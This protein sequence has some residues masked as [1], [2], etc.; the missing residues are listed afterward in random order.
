MA[1]KEKD[2]RVI[3]LANLVADTRERKL[4]LTLLK[5]KDILD[6]AE[7]G[8]VDFVRLR[9][10]VWEYN[11]LQVLILVLRQDFSIIPGEWR[12]AVRLVDLLSQASSG[13]NLPRQEMRQFQEHHLPRALDYIFLLTRRIQAQ[14]TALKQDE[15]DQPERKKMEYTGYIKA[16]MESVVY[17]ASGYVTLVAEIL[18]SPWLLQLLITDEP[19]TVVAV[20]TM[21]DKVIR[22]YG[23]ALSQ[24]DQKIVYSIL[25]EL[26]YK[27]SVNNNVAVGAAATKCI[28]KICDAFRLIVDV[29]CTRYKGL[30]PLLGKWH[31]KGFARE[32]KQ[33]LVLLDTGSA[34][35]AEM[36]KYHLAAIYLQACWKGC[37][38]RIKLRRANAAFKKFQ[39]T[40]RLKKEKEERFR[41]QTKIDAEFYHH[42]KLNR[43]RIMREFKERRLHLI[44]IMP[45]VQIPRF[46]Q[47]EQSDAAVKIQ[48][49]WRGHKERNRLPGRQEVAR[50]VKAVIK[51]Q[52]TVRRWMDR[53]DKRR[54]DVTI[55]L[56]PPGLTD[57]KRLE[58]HQQIENWRES[59][60]T[61][62]K[63]PEELLEIHTKAAE[64]LHHH[65]AS[66][67]SQRRTQQQRDALI[68][69]LDT[70]SELIL[71]APPLKSVT[72]KDVHMYTSRS[73]PVGAKARSNH[74]ETMK[75]LQLPWWKRLGE[76]D[77]EAADFEMY[78]EDIIF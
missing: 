1:N 39:R 14:I 42:L 8:E 23:V 26:I 37:I 69:R 5:L 21:M 16:I 27:I 15:V 6:T 17:L 18:K 48:T 33:L 53:L 41:E 2:Q 28:L 49:M 61:P 78:Q 63:T 46:L 32:L 55:S 71:L 12:T 11:L 51:I 13:L 57:V 65:Y 60:P 74:V 52:R 70:D 77:E 4:P 20:I 24:I 76:E 7:A 73:V 68:A 66:V 35:K 64:M 44:E 9:R 29:L 50:Q 36:E 30:R 38:T 19:D 75:R 62:S 67:R 43:Q 10:E 54:E 34:K 47:R 56:K 72:Q 25:D 22:A 40:Y 58:L 31:G 3:N 45:A 59:N